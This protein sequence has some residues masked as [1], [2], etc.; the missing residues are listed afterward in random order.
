MDSVLRILGPSVDHTLHPVAPSVCVLL[1]ASAPLKLGSGVDS[2]PGR[3]PVCAACTRRLPSLGP[4]LS[5][6]PSP[7]GASPAAL[8]PPP[9]SFSP[10]W[11]LLLMARA[12]G[13][14]FLEDRLESVIHLSLPKVSHSSLPVNNE[15]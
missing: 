3:L 6:G 7:N 11:L 2:E 9:S 4:A 12:L 15:H 10:F 1:P 8:P 5:S 13:F 14:K